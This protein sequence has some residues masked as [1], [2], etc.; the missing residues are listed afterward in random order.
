MP[1]FKKNLKLIATAVGLVVMLV[2]GLA[3]PGVTQ[4]PSSPWTPPFRPRV[5]EAL[6]QAISG[7]LTASKG[8]ILD[9]ENAAF[10]SHPRLTSAYIPLHPSL[11]HGG[12]W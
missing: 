8:D 6:N 11:D 4:Q 12:A 7:T 2:M 3:M 1:M 10:I 5:P 9:I